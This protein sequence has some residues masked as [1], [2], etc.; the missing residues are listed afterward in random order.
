MF[1]AAYAGGRSI[2]IDFG[3]SISVGIRGWQK[4]RI[5]A[6]FYTD[7]GTVCEQFS[8]CVFTV[9]WPSPFVDWS[10]A[11]KARVPRRELFLMRSTED[12]ERGFVFAANGVATFVIS[13]V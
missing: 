4:G 8:I 6:T 10:V 7:D 13:T 3:D 11:A 12:R 1:P 5:V 9:H 2:C